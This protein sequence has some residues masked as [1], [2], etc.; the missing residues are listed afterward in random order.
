MYMISCKIYEICSIIL[1]HLDMEPTTVNNK[2]YIVYYIHIVIL[3][4]SIFT[5]V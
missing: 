3:N 2:A 4:D 1:H 5:K